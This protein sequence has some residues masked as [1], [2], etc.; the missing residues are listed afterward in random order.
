MLKKLHQIRI[1]G[2]RPGGLRRHRDGVIKG[3]SKG[4]TQQLSGVG[5]CKSLAL[6]YNLRRVLYEIEIIDFDFYFIFIFMLLLFK[7]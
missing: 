6:D 1:V 7:S 2:C 3:W 5:P 4:I